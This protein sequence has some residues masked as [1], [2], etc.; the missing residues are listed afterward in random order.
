MP[1][2]PRQRNFQRVRRLEEGS[3]SC[4]K[5]IV[6]LDFPK[7]AIIAM[8]ERNNNYI[9]PHG[10]TE[11]DSKDKL[12]VLSDKQEAIIDVYECLRIKR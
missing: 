3:Y 9:T 4:G 5:K 11:I 8:I 1:D 2:R 7:N 6:D 10:A 12:I